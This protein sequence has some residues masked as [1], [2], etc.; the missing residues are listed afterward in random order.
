MWYA[1]YITFNSTYMIEGHLDLSKWP[2][3][4]SVRPLGCMASFIKFEFDW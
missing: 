4:K 3:I 2:K 1:A